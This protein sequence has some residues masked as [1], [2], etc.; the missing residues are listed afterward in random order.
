M[1]ILAVLSWSPIHSHMITLTFRS[2]FTCIRTA[3]FSPYQHSD[4]H[5]CPHN[6][7]LSYA[8]RSSPM[9]RTAWPSWTSG[10]VMWPPQWIA[11]THGSFLCPTTAMPR[12]LCSAK[13]STNLCKFPSV[14]RSHL[15]CCAESLQIYACCTFMRE[16][17]KVNYR[18]LFFSG[19]ASF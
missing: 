6:F 10:W 1:K 5:L 12:L 2:S 3:P 15:S 19:H 11:P 8:C 17:P 9:C 14:L 18:H 4:P 16:C 7:I 13:L